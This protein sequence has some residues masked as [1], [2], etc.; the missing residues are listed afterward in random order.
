[1]TAFLTVVVFEVGSD[2]GLV[3]NIALNGFSG[4]SD[5]DLL[6]VAFLTTC[7]TGFFGAGAVFLTGLAETFLAGCFGGV[8]AAGLPKSPNVAAGALFAG[9][10]AVTLRAYALGAGSL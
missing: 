5:Y 2:R 3:A 9:W 7:L 6:G 1:M 4:G 8:L 10:L